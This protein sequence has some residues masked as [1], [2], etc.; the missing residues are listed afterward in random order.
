MNG[1]GYH[2]RYRQR[3]RASVLP[4][5]VIIVV[6]IAVLFLLFLI[7]GNGLNKKTQDGGTDTSVTQTQNE[8]PKAAP[9]SVA[10]FFLDTAAVDNNIAK[11][12][13]NGVN[14]LSV[15]LK[16]SDQTLL[17]SSDVA[18]AFEKQ[19]GTLDVSSLVSRARSRGMYVSAYF[20]L[21]FVKEK[22][23]DI[24]AAKLGYEAALVSELCSEGVD[25]VMVYAPDATYENYTELIRFAESVK[26]TNVNAKIGISVR[27]ELYSHQNAAIIIDDLFDAF[28]IVGIDLSEI[29]ENDMDKNVESALANNL[30]YILRYNARVILPNVED[31]ELSKKLFDILSASN[32]HNYQ[33]VK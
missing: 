12:S 28:D 11:L 2:A 13:S 23:T 1:R 30:Y 24:R 25:D 27:S 15:T 6:V 3:R 26:Q 5:I 18:K 32:V 8:P 9:D 19:C 33:Y 17:Y 10:C 21:E 4:V 14:A 20:T 7:V 22:N 29:E 31:T 16:S